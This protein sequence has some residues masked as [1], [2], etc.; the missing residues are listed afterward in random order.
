MPGCA[1]L[2]SFRT[3]RSF[4]FAGEYS[5]RPGGLPAVSRKKAQVRRLQTSRARRAR[6]RPLSRSSTLLA[7]TTPGIVPETASTD[8][9]AV[10]PRARCIARYAPASRRSVPAPIHRYQKEVLDHGP[11]ER[12]DAHEHGRESRPAAPSAAHHRH[13]SR[14]A[15]ECGNHPPSIS[16]HLR[17][18]NA[19][20]LRDRRVPGHC[21]RKGD[22]RPVAVDGPGPIAPFAQ[23]GHTP[24]DGGV[25]GKN[26]RWIS[27]GT[28]AGPPRCEIR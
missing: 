23:G 3:R 13:T 7:E 8:C 2:R 11:L 25:A 16:P 19:P 26:P 1:L 28:S 21:E 5:P 17:A 20:A 14:G 4:A 10:A 24:N 6:C 12:L 18:E 27:P 15:H 22:S 9:A